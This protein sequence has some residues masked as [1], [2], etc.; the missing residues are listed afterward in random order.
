MIHHRRLWPGET[1]RL[2]LIHK[3]GYA[4]FQEEFVVKSGGSE[5]HDFELTP[6]AH[7]SG[8]V[9]DRDSGAPLK[10]FTVYAHDGPGSEGISYYSKPSGEDGAFAIGLFQITRILLFVVNYLCHS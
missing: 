8:H 10:G 7:L 6:G 9:V 3:T 1:N 4:D 2:L 5:T